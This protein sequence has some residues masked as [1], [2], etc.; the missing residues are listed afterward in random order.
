MVSEYYLLIFL[1]PLSYVLYLF[2]RKVNIKKDHILK[3]I[4]TLF[5]FIFYSLFSTYIVS[6][7][8]NSYLIISSLLYCLAVYSDELKL[9][10][11]F[12]Y[13][14]YFWLSLLLLWGFI[15]FRDTALLLGI[16]PLMVISRGMTKSLVKVF[17]WVAIVFLNMT[18]L[19]MGVKEG[20]AL[21]SLLTE[22]VFVFLLFFTFP[23]RRTNH[24]SM[25]LQTLLSLG[26]FHVA[27]SSFGMMPSI[28]VKLVICAQVINFFL[29]LKTE[30]IVYLI[31]G[32]LFGGIVLIPYEGVSNLATI[33]LIVYACIF[34][35]E[36]YKLLKLYQ[37]YSLAHIA[38]LLFIFNLLLGIVESSPPIKVISVLIVMA[39]ISVNFMFKERLFLSRK[40]IKFSHG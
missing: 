30:S 19:D 6:R 21:R 26:V 20:L 13:F 24:F 9:M 27:V 39:T 35:F 16:M 40:L 33:G 3:A 31:Y 8:E 37:L 38:S 10:N 14:T 17:L 25:L 36:R 34:V 5:F 1:Y 22:L 18:I 28:F 29:F 7:S 23:S 15:S 4:F 32:I 2:G 12:K 11:I